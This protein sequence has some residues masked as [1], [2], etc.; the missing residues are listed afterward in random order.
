M[1]W[2][3]MLGILGGLRWITVTLRK[4]RLARE[5]AAREKKR[6]RAVVETSDDLKPGDKV[7]I[8]GVVYKVKST[9]DVTDR[10][11]R[12]KSAKLKPEK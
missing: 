10:H 8:D 11:G 5:K 9:R 6:V 12:T 3:H 2:L 1:N 7:E 4:G